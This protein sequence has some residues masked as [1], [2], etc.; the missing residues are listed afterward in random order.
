[1]AGD[2]GGSAAWLEGLDGMIA[3][4]M[5]KGWTDETGAVRAHVESG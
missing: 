5:T 2:L 3:F 4:A 1:L